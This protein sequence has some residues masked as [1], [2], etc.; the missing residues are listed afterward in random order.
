MYVES[1]TQWTFANYASADTDFAVLRLT[2]LS[3]F[4]GKNY[5]ECN[6]PRQL[7]AEV[8]SP[9]LSTQTGPLLGGRRRGH[10]HG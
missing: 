6:C 8:I 9:F 5:N 10:H 2:L 7:P 4:T 3:A 1:H